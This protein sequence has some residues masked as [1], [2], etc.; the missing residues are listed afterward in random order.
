MSQLSDGDFQRLQETLLELKSRNYTLEDQARKQKHALGDSTS[1]VKVLEQELSKASRTIEKSKKITE[2]Q[3]ILKESENLQRKLASQEEEFHLQNKT[4]LQELQLLASANE[5]LIKENKNNFETDCN[6]NASALQTEVSSLKAKLHHC[7]EKLQSKELETITDEFNNNDDIDSSFGG[8]TNLTQQFEDLVI[9][10]DSALAEKKLVLTH[11]NE[12]K[13]QL[14]NSKEELDTKSAELD[15]L[16]EKLKKKQKNWNEAQQEKEFLLTSQDNL[17]FQ[18]EKEKSIICA[19]MTKTINKLQI[20]LNSSNQNLAD[21]KT[22]YEEENQKVKLI[23][24]EQ[25]EKL[26]RYSEEAFKQLEADNICLKNDLEHQTIEK[27]KAQICSEKCTLDMEKLTLK[28]TVII[29]EKEKILKEKDSLELQLNEIT[30]IS[31][32]RKCLL[33]EKVIELQ[34]FIAISRNTERDLETKMKESELE[35]QDTVNGLSIQKSE[36]INE[37]EF[38]IQGLEE[39]VK[40]LNSWP[41]KYQ[42]INS[43]L[44][45]SIS[46]KN[47]LE[48]DIELK[49]NL[50]EKIRVD[51]A[52][53]FNQIEVQQ[54]D[55]LALLKK[56]YEAK[57]KEYETQIELVNVQKC[58]FEEQV[59]KLRQEVRDTVEERKIHE[60]KGQSLVKDLKRQVQQERKRAEKLTE[61]MK[62]CFE[63]DS[64]LSGTDRE[65]NGL[66]ADRSSISSW[67]LMSGE[68]GSS[69]HLAP[70][71]GHSTPAHL[72]SSPLEQVEEHQKEFFQVVQENETLLARV[73]KLQETVWSLDEKLLMLESSGAGMAQ[74]LFNKS[75]LITNY[76]M[77]EKK[78][79]MNKAST[80]HTSG[81]NKMKSFMDKMDRF[82]HQP[83]SSGGPSKEVTN[84]QKMLEETL[85]KNMHLQQDLE[86]MSLEVVRLSKLANLK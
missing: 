46:E 61:K 22:F 5:E 83:G 24:N 67:S 51:N 49:D 15:S 17:K 11:N 25:N 9:K 85:T 63:T 14:S 6:I 16:K 2:V 86:H 64:M 8:Y 54:N 74:E 65:P 44:D 32:K 19:D 4:L 40:E 7:E 66:D 33:D 34:D 81:E 23:V 78:Q 35:H 43:E 53:Q 21:C 41:E 57:A 36:I 29:S 76:C 60:K 69:Q 70:S 58:E 62:E 3:K 48:Q 20:Q 13:I 42:V 80:N 52:K 55:Q 10:Y 77:D 84:M 31:D 75:K 79:N 59:V 38:T 68:R 45:K 27:E 39:Q 82:V 37:M 28:Y 12:L 30:K 72:S 26:T 47:Q 73:A 1:R 18:M 71:G 56:Q 50:V